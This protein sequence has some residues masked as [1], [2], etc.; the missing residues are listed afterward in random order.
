MVFLPSR[1][2]IL[3]VALPGLRGVATPS[4]LTVTIDVSVLS[5]LAVDRSIPAAAAAA[6]TSSCCI[7]ETVVPIRAGICTAKGSTKSPW[8]VT[9]TVT[10]KSGKPA[11]M[12]V[13]IQLS[14]GS[15]KAGGPVRRR[16]V[17]FIRSLVTES[18]VLLL[19]E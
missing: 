13:R 17:L 18:K 2:L 4:L 1:D 11:C 9:I 10:T 14:V 3:T 5:V 12:I 16:T 19:L 8:R 15:P 6:F 7:N